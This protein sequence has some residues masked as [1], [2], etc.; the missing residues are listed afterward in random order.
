MQ[1]D[2][3]VNSSPKT[4]IIAITHKGSGDSVDNIDARVRH[5]R[6]E[7]SGA[8]EGSGA[9]PDPFFVCDLQSPPSM[10]MDTGRVALYHSLGI[11]AGL[12]AL[13]GVPLPLR[14]TATWW[15][16][17][18]DEASSTTGEPVMVPDWGISMPLDASG[19]E[20]RRGET[21][22]RPRS[23]HKI[24][25]CKL[26]SM[27]A[28]NRSSMLLSPTLDVQRVHDSLGQLRT[29]AGWDEGPLDEVLQHAKFVAPLSNGY[30]AELVPEGGR[31]KYERF[32]TAT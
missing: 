5:L 12:A 7:N 15:M 16:L 28:G 31:A 25:P 6:A 32:R 20:L 2:S 26:S 13:T 29:E 30:M 3:T 23:P 24:L 10:C 22:S 8:N 21:T 11:I 19:R 1:D 18:A 27:A 17:V 14:L 4:P 9:F